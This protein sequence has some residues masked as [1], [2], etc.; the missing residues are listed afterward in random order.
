MFKRVRSFLAPPVFEGDEEK[1]RIAGLVNT[2]LWALIV[3][4][5]LAS[6]IVVIALRVYALMGTIYASM[7]IPL[8]AALWM[9][10]RGYVRAASLTITIALWLVLALTGFFIGGVVNSGYM[11][12]VLVII[13]AALLLGGQAG[14]IFAAISVLLVL[15]VFAIESLGFLPPSA[16]ANDS[17]SYLINHIMNYGISG[18]LLY[19]AMN[20]LTAA[21]RRARQLNAESEAQQTQLQTLVEERTR[22]F[23]RYASYL[24]ATTAVARESAAAMGDPQALLASAARVIGEQFGYYHVGIYVL[25]DL[26]EWAEPRAI[27]GHGQQLLGRGFRLRVGIEGMIGDV[28]RRGVYRLAADVSQDFTYL[29]MDDLP[30]TRSELVLPLKTGEVV[31]GVL[32]VQSTQVN[33]F[34]DQDVQ[35]LQALADQVSIALNNARLI[36]QTREAVEIERRIYRTQTGE[37]WRT[38]LGGRQTLGFYSTGPTTVPADSDLWQPEMKVALQTGRTVRDERDVHR[39]AVP[40]RVRDEVIGVIDF[41]KPGQGSTWTAEETALVESLTEQLGVALESARLYQDTQRAAARERVV[42]QVT[43]RI[44]ETLDMEAMLRTAAEQMRRALDLED[45]VV[46]L[47]ASESAVT[48]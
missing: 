4:I 1:S 37:A 46:R 31:A 34:S 47:A 5:S 33:A 23:E 27:F 9:L 3:L 12:I 26:N 14:V 11:T 39:L 40:V 30:D 42:G 43:G 35:V 36:E 18:S 24:Q 8:L 16:A 25:D 13:I 28:A 15:L 19:L 48:E 21:L 10:H 22:D 32:D 29:H 7:M 20:S 6:L 2:I 44:R 45:L 38:L 17:L 41:A